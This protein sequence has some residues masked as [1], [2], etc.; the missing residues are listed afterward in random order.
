MSYIFSNYRRENVSPSR[1]PASGID[2][3]MVH[4][5]RRQGRIERAKVVRQ[6]LAYFK[7]GILNRIATVTRI[8]GGI[9]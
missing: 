9:S 4:R 5:I 6:F 1:V 8:G 3:E 2:Q 7:L